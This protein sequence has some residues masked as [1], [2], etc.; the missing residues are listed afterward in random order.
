MASN[1]PAMFPISLLCFSKSYN[2]TLTTSPWTVLVRGDIFFTQIKILKQ[3]GPVPARDQYFS[4]FLPGRQAVREEKCAIE[5]KRN[6]MK[7][8]HN[9]IY[10][11][12]S[13]KAFQDD[14]QHYLFL[15]SLSAMLF[16]FLVQFCLFV[17]F[18]SQRIYLMMWINVLSMCAY[19]LGVKLVSMGYFKAAGTLLTAY[20]TLYV[21]YTVAILGAVDGIIFYLLLI[22]ICQ[23]IIPYASATWR[24]VSGAIIWLCMMM[25]IFASIYYT[26]KYHIEI[27]H[28]I[29]TILNVHIGVFGTVLEITI[30]D[31][32]NRLLADY[33]IVQ[34]ER[35]ANQAHRDQLTGL[36][37]RRYAE[38]V[39]TQISSGSNLTQYIVAMADIDDFKLVNDNYGHVVG[40]EVLR[41]ISK[42]MCAHL[43]KSDYV[44]RWGGEEFLMLLATTDSYMAMQILE[45]LRIGVAG[46]IFDTPQ[47]SFSITISIGAAELDPFN[48][49][50][51]ID[52]S[53]R[54]LYMGKLNGKNV[55]ITQDN[56]APEMN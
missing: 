46:M 25:I 44:F 52:L 39:F 24:A 26:P 30:G 51:S 13:A 18:I 54:R 41:K 5:Q 48:I 11:L 7:I 22:M 17:V 4:T 29:M 9:K 56:A 50:G 21:L 45:K 20:T 19:I 6:G 32:L 15:T 33:N 27:S 53:D 47:G 28:L 14:A 10:Y 12:L 1:A 49:Q 31:F 37:N 34:M 43:R 38:Q 2:S 8:L 55:V 3:Y 40:D 35:M 36:H 42:Y 16:A 23:I